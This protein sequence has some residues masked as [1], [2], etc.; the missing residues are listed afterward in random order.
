MDRSSAVVNHNSQLGDL[1]RSGHALSLV[2]LRVVLMGMKIGEIVFVKANKG[3][4]K[5]RKNKKN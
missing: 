3:G 5:E 4:K 2:G 1:R